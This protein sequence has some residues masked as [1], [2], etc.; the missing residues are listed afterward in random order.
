MAL[1]PKPLLSIVLPAYEEA[2]NLDNL[3][4]RLAAVAAQI[5]EQASRLPGT[6]QGL[7][8]AVAGTAAAS[9]GG[10]PAAL[11]QPNAQFEIVVAD[12][13]E[14]RDETPAICKK[15]GVRYVPRRG[16]SLYGHA[17]RTAL[18]EAAGEWVIFMDADGSHNPG[19]LPELW[20]YR[21][22][23]DL[24]IASRYVE[25]GKTEN[26]AVLILMSLVINVMFRITLGLKCF[27]VSNSFRLYRG[28]DLRK[29]HLKCNH[30]DIVEEILV[31]LITLHPGYRL[32][33]VPFY[34]EKRK[35]GKTKRNLLTFALGYF[36][37]LLRLMKL[38]R[39]AK[40]AVHE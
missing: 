29:L 17:I 25:G 10:A 26:P 16:G 3:L 6:R 13:P 28:D 5:V 15:H 36:I 24:V 11:S 40:K 23:F 4:P 31:K 37:T 19:F 7:D 14:P 33:E 38:K 27:D 22:D 20:R 34:F 35:A 8:S 18:E 32:K 21:N 2:A 30:F 9:T 1:T 12:T 39:E